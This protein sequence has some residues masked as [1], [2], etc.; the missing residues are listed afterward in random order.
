MLLEKIKDL[1]FERRMKKQRYKRGF[2]DSDCWGLDYW[3]CETLPKMILRLRDMKHGYPCGLEFKEYD[4][5]PK[6]WKLQELDKCKQVFEKEDWEFSFEDPMVKWYITLT[7]I[8][9]CLQQADKDLELPNEYREQFFNELFRDMEKD[10][11]SEWF[12]HLWK[13]VDKGYVYNPPEVNKDLEKNYYKV[14]EENDLY[15]VKC[16]NEA[17]DLLKEYFYCLWD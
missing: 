5:F 15:K 11:I 12:K 8:A 1:R 3:I 7:R 13:K 14:E 9:F 6:E 16:K 10:T 2:S 4:N 17:M